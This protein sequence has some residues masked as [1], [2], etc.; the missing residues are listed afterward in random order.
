M[1]TQFVDPPPLPPY[2]PLRTSTQWPGLVDAM[3]GLLGTHLN[4]IDPSSTYQPLF[5]F[6]PHGA[7][8]GKGKAT[9]TL[10]SKHTQLVCGPYH[11]MSPSQLCDRCAS[12]SR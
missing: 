4:A 7:V 8:I 11:N 9:L 10:Q 1:A 12:L 2:L 5:S 3:S 6:R